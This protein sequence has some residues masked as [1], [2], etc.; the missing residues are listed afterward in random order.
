MLYTPLLP[1]EEYWVALN[2]L[3]IRPNTYEISNYGNIRRI[4]DKFPIRPCILLNEYGAYRVV[5]LVPI[6]SSKPK[7]Y[8][9]HRLVGIVFIPNPNNYPQINHINNNGM[10]DCSINLEWVTP[11]YNTNYQDSS[12]KYLLSNLEN[13]DIYVMISNGHSNQDIKNKYTQIDDLYIESIREAYIR[14]N[15]VSEF[16]YENRRVNSSKFPNDTVAYVCSLYQDKGMTYRNYKEIAGLIGVKLTDK[17]SEEA[18]YMFCSNLY[19]RKH[20]THISKK[21]NW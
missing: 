15:P 21:F 5:N 13:Y 12:K 2:V 3:D 9:V 6:N 17:K 19:K 4:E 16:D 20:H 1:L 10:D 8:L 14:N 18:F 7:K 11:E